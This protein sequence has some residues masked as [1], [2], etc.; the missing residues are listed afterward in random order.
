MRMSGTQFTCK[1]TRTHDAAR[2]PVKNGSPEK[3]GPGGGR[4]LSEPSATDLQFSPTCLS[5]QLPAGRTQ[6]KD[7]T[8]QIPSSEFSPLYRNNN[9]SLIRIAVRIK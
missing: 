3:G 5:G 7:M 9:I 6:K 4:D 8:S 2:H 1:E